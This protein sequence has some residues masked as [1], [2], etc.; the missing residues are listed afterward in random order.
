MYLISTLIF[1]IIILVFYYYHTS[2][3]VEILD[4]DKY[5][6]NVKPPIEPIDKFNIKE[7][8]I[9]NEN[10]IIHNKYKKELEGLKKSKYIID[11]KNEIK[12]QKILEMRNEKIN[13]NSKK[14][15]IQEL[16]KKVDLTKDNIKSLKISFKLELNKFLTNVKQNRISKN[17]L[18]SIISGLSKQL[19]ENN[20]LIE[21]MH[22]SMTESNSINI[23]DAEYNMYIQ[24]LEEYLSLLNIKNNIIQKKL[25]IYIKFL[26]NY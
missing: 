3:N 11:Q 4:I 12:N 26:N 25:N 22:I 16:Q 9:I 2:R 1:F 18:N 15:K 7:Y 24:L 5:K 23:N 14:L 17:D 21:K 10:I 8:G 20:K 6:L 13:K 19:I